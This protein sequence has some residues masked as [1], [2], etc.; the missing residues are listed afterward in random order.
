M[1]V[2]TIVLAE[3]NPEMQE[4]LRTLLVA[5]FEVVASASDGQQA[6]DFA[7]R[8]RPDILVTDISMPI[9]NGLQAASRLLD[10]GCLAKVIFVSAHDDNDFREAAKSLGAF[11]YILKCRIDTELIPAIKGA[12]QGQR[13]PLHSVAPQS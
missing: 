10:L 13:A 3:D 2:P 12:V 1:Q 5:H 6:I 11:G 7:L 4:K 9:V 8:H